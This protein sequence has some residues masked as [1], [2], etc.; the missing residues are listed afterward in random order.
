MLA[1][2]RCHGIRR[3][4]PHPKPNSTHVHAQVEGIGYDFIPTVLDRALVD[5][6]VKTGGGCR[7]CGVVWRF[8]AARLLLAHTPLTPP[9]THP[10]PHQPPNNTDRESLLMARRLIR[11]EGLLCGGS[12]GSA[13]AAAV[14]VRARDG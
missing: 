10:H 1:G 8:G 14:Q 9:S 3:P 2:A 6:W 5:E 7:C 11:D 13:M 12:C 4:P